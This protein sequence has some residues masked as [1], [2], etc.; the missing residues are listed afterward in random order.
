MYEVLGNRECSIA[1][2]ITKLHEEYIRGTLEE[3]TK[4]AP[5]PL[6]GEMVVVVEGNKEIKVLTEDDIKSLLEEE[7]NQGKSLKDAIKEVSKAY[8]L[9]KNLVYDIATSLKR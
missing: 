1:R 3:L 9:K 7:L 6:K 4:I 8:S 5:S 2:E